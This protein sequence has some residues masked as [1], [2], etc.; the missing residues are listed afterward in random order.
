[1]LVFFGALTVIALRRQP[2]SSPSLPELETYRAATPATSAV[3]KR[4]VFEKLLRARPSIFVN[5]D[6]RNDAVQIPQRLRAQARCVLTYG[7]KLMTPIPDLRLSDRGI[8]ATL[9]FGEEFERTFVPWV[10]VFAIVGDD[11]RG[12]LWPADLPLD[13][14]T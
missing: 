7:R 10:A 12:T 11:K 1:L 2:R 3:S 5:F 6:P 14:E 8:S 4:E 13:L 9:L